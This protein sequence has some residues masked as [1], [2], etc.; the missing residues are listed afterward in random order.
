MQ[1]TQ[2][3]Q[4]LALTVTLPDEIQE[5]LTDVDGTVYDSSTA[6]HK[7]PHITVIPPRKTFDEKDWQEEIDNLDELP[8]SLTVISF[9][10]FWN[11]SKF[12]FK[13]KLDA[14]TDVE[15]PH[16]TLFDCG[17]PDDAEQAWKAHID[18]FEQ[19]EGRELAI[20]S[21]AVIEKGEGVVYEQPVDDADR[22]A[23]D[24]NDIEQYWN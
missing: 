15:T 13:G 14:D 7:M 12:G 8:T 10:S 17:D 5:D 9:N 21:I 3:E 19:Y 1:S 24:E 6:P 23:L 4:F 2:S 22:F 20:E 16:V 11:S 18:T